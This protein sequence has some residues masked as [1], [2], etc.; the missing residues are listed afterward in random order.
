MGGG[1]GGS[2]FGVGTGGVG[3]EA[4]GQ[5]KDGEGWRRMADICNI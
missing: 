4:G 3:K 1:D 2:D 5:E